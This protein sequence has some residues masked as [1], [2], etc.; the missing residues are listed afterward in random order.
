MTFLNYVMCIIAFPPRMSV[1]TLNYNDPMVDRK[2]DLLFPTHQC[3]PS[4]IGMLSCIRR[5]VDI[6]LP[7]SWFCSR[8]G[9]HP[10]RQ[11]HDCT[12]SHKT[13]LVGNCTVTLV[14]H[15]CTSM[16]DGNDVLQ[17]SLLTYDQE[18]YPAREF[19]AHDVTRSLLRL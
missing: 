4:W 5:T 13:Y 9:T 2:E 1:M 18:V 10:P 11:N 3:P 12:A 14:E 15:P 8:Q 17:G 7:L 19:T 16:S 6:P